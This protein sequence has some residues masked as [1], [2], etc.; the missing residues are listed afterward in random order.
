MNVREEA[1]KDAANHKPQ[2]PVMRSA[3]TFEERYAAG[4]ALR[5]ACR[6]SAHATWKSRQSRPDAVQLVLA[7]SAKAGYR[8]FPRQPSRSPGVTIQTTGTRLVSDA[9]LPSLHLRLQKRRKSLPLM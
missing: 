3:S 4:K 1:K 7:R 2:V 6:R 5:R 8:R 9:K